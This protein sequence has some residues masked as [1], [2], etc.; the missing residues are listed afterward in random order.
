MKPYLFDAMKEILKGAECSFI[1]EIGTHKGSTSYQLVNHF[2]P[3]V[4][5]LVFYGYDVFDLERGNTQFHNKE[6]NGKSSH[7]TINDVRRTLGKVPHKNFK[8]KLF[9]G[10]TT[11]T[12]V[13]PI[14]FDFVYID[15]GH[16][17]ETVKHDYNMVKD[18]KIIIFDDVNLLQ[19]KKLIQELID[20]NIKVEVMKPAIDKKRQW[21]IIKK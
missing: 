11:E 12:L 9:K 2:A 13:S 1:G 8:Y 10:Y 6:H 19:I 17:Y 3:K 16:S 18:S 5:E 15:G 21:A 4:K 14:A 7:A 20:Q